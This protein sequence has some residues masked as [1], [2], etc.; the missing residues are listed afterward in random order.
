V[1]PGR[2]AR[3]GTWATKCPRTG[4]PHVNELLLRQSHAEFYH[5][6][7]PHAHP[8]AASSPLAIVNWIGRHHPP[9]TH[10]PG[11]IPPTCE[12][13]SRAGMG[14]IAL[15]GRRTS[16]SRSETTPLHRH[17]AMSLARIG[18]PGQTPS[19]YHLRM[20]AGM[21]TRAADPMGLQDCR[22]AASQMRAPLLTRTPRRNWRQWVRSPT[23]PAI[24][25]TGIAPSRG[26]SPLTGKVPRG[27][28]PPWRRSQQPMPSAVDR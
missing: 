6:F 27:D 11:L 15:R 21:A 4:M 20:A 17:C 14:E 25:P 28:T 12:D 5:R 1:R 7:V 3:K 23:T 22:L 13:V 19:P 9:G 8:W 18:C 16:R 24:A 26:V 10:A 2:S